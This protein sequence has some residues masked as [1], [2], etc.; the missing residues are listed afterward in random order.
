M[1]LIKI[2]TKPIGCFFSLIGALVIFVVL[3]VGGLI[4]LVDE[5]APKVAET[6][7]TEATGF[8][9]QVRE[10]SVSFK[11]QTITLTDIEIDN[12]QDFVDRDFL[13]IAELTLGLD[14]EKWNENQVA[15]SLIR[16]D[17][18]ELNFNQGNF[19][20]SNLDAFIEA[21]EENWELF[22]EQIHNQATQEGQTVPENVVIGEVTLKLGRVVLASPMGDQTISRTV[23][24][25]YEATFTEVRS[26]RPIIETVARDLQQTGLSDIAKSLREASENM[27]DEL[28]L[29]LLQDHLD[30]Q[31]KKQQ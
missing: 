27:N 15:L 14:R 22:L 13:R 28:T 20:I 21:A 4:W 30:E 8:P 2:V 26:L 31:F 23:N 18:K 10:G 24:L 12:P 16:L 1:G 5:M 6:A 19:D 3:V 17:I 29:K 25:N 9:T 11:D 7:I